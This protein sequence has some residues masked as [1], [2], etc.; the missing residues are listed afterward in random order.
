MKNII[1]TTLQTLSIPFT[2]KGRSLWTRQNTHTL[3]DISAVLHQFKVGNLAV[4]IR[5][6]S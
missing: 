5:S 3:E 6:I 1:E 4:R 2:E